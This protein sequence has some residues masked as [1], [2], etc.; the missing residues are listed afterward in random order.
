[1]LSVSNRAIESDERSLRRSELGASGAEFA[2]ALIIVALIIGGLFVAAPGWGRQVACAAGS[3]IASIVGSDWSCGDGG[4]DPN[5]DAEAHKPTEACT[6]NQRS[7][8]VDLSVSLA[9]SVEVNGGLVIEQMSD[10]TYR[11]TEKG[12]AK[13]GIGIGAGGGVEV[14]IDNQSYGS[15]AAA[16]ADING[17]AEAGQTYVVDS[18][19][20]KN[21]LVNHLLREAVLS[22]PVGQGA[23]WLFNKATGYQPPSAKE[24]YVDF[25]VEGTASAEATQDLAGG[26]LSA[27]RALA[28]GM[29]IDVETG[30]VTTYYKVSASHAA[31]AGVAGS[32]GEAEASGEIM[33]AVTTSRNDPNKV[34][35]VTASGMYNAQIG[36]TTPVPDRLDPAPI[37]GAFEERST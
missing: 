17:T 9:V 23:N 12:G 21:D 22:G 32:G 26:N 30:D 5:G 33:V 14:T 35:N 4:T 7:H 24:H 29:K 2:G 15:Y 3:A 31:Q 27:S 34:L 18:E 25:G 13:V 11:V 16:G 8:S 36:A 19:Q 37:G 28:T 20:A 10:G 6:V 1:M